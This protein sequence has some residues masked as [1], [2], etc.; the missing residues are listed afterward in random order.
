MARARN[1]KPG[2]FTNETL[3]ECHPLARLLFQGLWCHADRE[4]RLEFRPKR[5]KAEVLPYDDCDIAELLDELAAR[6]FIA[7]FEA[8]GIQYIQVVNFAK[9]QNPHMREPAST[10]PAPDSPGASTVPARPLPPSLNPLPSSSAKSEMHRPSTGPAPD[11]APKTPERANGHA[12]DPAVMAEF[13][14][15]FW[16]AYPLRA[17]RKPAL[18]AFVV[19]RGKAPLD[20]IMLGLRRYKAK[21]AAPDAPKTKHAQGWLNDERWLDEEADPKPTASQRLFG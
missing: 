16:P 13:D 3:A 1:L 18:K 7:V 5:L 19:A 10:I 2:F 4:G 9:H 21:L 20:T 12:L 6:G 11:R 14:H 15:V 17:G 8:A